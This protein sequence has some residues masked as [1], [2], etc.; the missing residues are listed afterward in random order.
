MSRFVTRERVEEL[1]GFGQ[2]ER[3]DQ[4]GWLGGRKR[5]L[6]LGGGGVSIPQ[7]EVRDAGKQMRFDEGER[8]AE[9]WRVVQDISERIQRGGRIS[10]SHADRCTR[11][12]DGTKGTDSLGYG[13]ES[14]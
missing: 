13:G 10:L 3:E 7:G 12:A 9:A 4:P 5:F 11:V 1:G 14:A 8:G 2:G 6:G